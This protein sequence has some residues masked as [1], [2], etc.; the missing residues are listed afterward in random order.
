MPMMEGVHMTSPDHSP[1]VAKL[2]LFV[3]R[4][5]GVWGEPSCALCQRQL[6]SIYFTSDSSFFE[7]QRS[8]QMNVPGEPESMV[9]IMKISIIFEVV[10][11]RLTAA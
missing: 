1:K 10:K 9:A 4:C 7:L 5:G 11:T 2:W 8:L 6:A 3:G